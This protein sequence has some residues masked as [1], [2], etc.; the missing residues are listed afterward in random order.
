MSNYTDLISRL[1]KKTGPINLS[2]IVEL[3]EEQTLPADALGPGTVERGVAEE[4][5]AVAVP[6]ARFGAM[7]DGRTTPGCS[8]SAASTAMT[9]PGA[10]FLAGQRVIVPSVGPAIELRGVIRSVTNSTTVVLDRVAGRTVSNAAGTYVAAGVATT[11]SSGLSTTAGSATVTHSG[12][13]YT[14]ADI[15]ARLYVVGAGHGPLTTTVAIGGT[16]SCVLADAATLA[17]SD[18]SVVHGSDNAAAVQAAVDYLYSIGG[19]VV[20]LDRGTYLFAASVAQKPGVSFRGKGMSSTTWRAAVS[21]TRLITYHLLGRSG[22][23]SLEDMT[24]HGFADQI[25]Y[26]GGDATDKMIS[27][28]NFDYAFISRVRCIYSRHMSLTAD[29]TNVIVRDCIV[30]KSLR[31]GISVTNCQHVVVDGC[32]VDGCGDDSIAAHLQAST[33]GIVNRSIRITNNRVTNGFGIKIHGARNA[34]V[35]DNLIQFWRGYAVS[36]GID[37]AADEGITTRHNIIIS[38]NAIKDGMNATLVQAGSIQSAIYING[39]SSL[40]VGDVAIASAIGSYS[41]GS[42]V[43]PE[44]YVNL[45]GQLRTDNV[46]T[47]AYPQAANQNLVIANNAITQTLGAKGAN[48][49]SLAEIE[50]YGFGKLW[51]NIGY[52]DPVRTTTLMQTTRAIDLDGDFWDTIIQGN[53]LVGQYDCVRLKNYTS[54]KGIQIIGNGMTRSIH[55][56]IFEKNTP[57]TDV[58]VLITSNIFDMDPL[59]EAV[60]A[61]ERTQ[62]FDGTWGNTTDATWCGI[63]ARFTRGLRVTNN[64]FRN[65]RK[66]IDIG[67]TIAF[68]K[69]NRYFWDFAS[70]KGIGAVSYPVDNHHFW[71]D[72]DPT[73][74]TYGQHSSTADSAFIRFAGAQPSSGYYYAGQMV[75]HQAPSRSNAGINTVGWRRLTTGNGHTSSDWAEVYDLGTTVLKGS[76]TWNPTTV[77]AANPQSSPAIT[78]SG[79]AIGDRVQVTASINLGGLDLKA[80]VTSAN[81]VTA[82]LSQPDTDAAGIDPNSFTVTAWV[83]K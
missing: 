64:D 39:A 25:P 49:A 11:I 46:I 13:A 74:G 36:V 32:T 4:L 5:Q 41:S 2:E 3:L 48:G 27:L 12:G 61:N 24:F 56:V 37:T 78:V 70:A 10:T 28:V 62:P 77:D 79:A 81:T 14:S 16:G 68:V 34:I 54:L 60:G 66:P 59:F 6:A 8:I 67:S 19:G 75:L 7:G 65:C 44:P 9:A 76:T 71:I 33:F 52:I 35:S 20:E 50:D 80:Q 83:W 15:G 45:G 51:C 58:D 63:V 55:G 73:S 22:A 1:N 38:N 31:D 47:S 23:T 82:Y 26:L 72:C 57:A 69:D 29:A 18:L 40:G 42:F 53:S 43:L 30:E 21:A 17:G